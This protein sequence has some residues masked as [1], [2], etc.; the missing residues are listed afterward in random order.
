L[1]GHEGSGEDDFEDHH[2]LH[3]RQAAVYGKD[4]RRVLEVDP[5]EI[6]DGVV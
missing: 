3:A 4:Q 5:D 6:A 2:E 1:H